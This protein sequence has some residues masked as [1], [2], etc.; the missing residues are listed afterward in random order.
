[1]L[2]IF[3]A[4]MMILPAPFL[5]AD[6]NNADAIVHNTAAW[7]GK[8]LHYELYTTDAYINVNSGD[9]GALTTDPSDIGGW[10]SPVYMWGFT[11]VDPGGPYAFD[12]VTRTGGLNVQTVPAGA[13]TSAGGLVGNAKFPAPIIEAGA[14]DDVYIT[15][16]NRGFFQ[17]RQAVQDEH[18][19]HLH[20][21]HAQ[22]VYDGFPES[23]GSYSEMM[24]MF[25]RS[26]QYGGTGLL[27]DGV[28]QLKNVTNLAPAWPSASYPLNALSTK[29]KDDWWNNLDAV[30]QQ[31][32][33]SDFG[34][35]IPTVLNALSPAGGIP[36][37]FEASMLT[38]PVDQRE[39][40]TQY[41]YYFRA[42]TPGTTMYHCHVVASEHVQMG[43]YGALVIRPRD[44][45]QKDMNH[46]L[47]ADGVGKYFDINYNGVR[48][49]NEPYY[50]D[51]DG[52]S[53]ISIGDTRI[54]ELILKPGP[55]PG[56]QTYT[57]AAG[58]IVNVSKTVYGVG[59]NS[60][61][62][63]EY[64]FL[65]SEVDPVWHQIIER[66]KGSFYPPNWKPQLWFVNGRT[67][68][69]TVFP[70]QN[71]NPEPNPNLWGAMWF[72]PEPR[73][74]T[75][76]S[77]QQGDRVLERWI[78]MGYQDHSMHQHGWHMELVGTDMEQ[79]RDGLGVPYR[80]VKFTLPIASGET[81]DT[82]TSVDPVYGEA[83]Y[84]AGSPI[85]VTNGTGGNNLKWRA[86]YP[87]HD[88]NDYMVTTNG[89]YP[90]G[91]LILFEASVANAQSPVTWDNPYTG[92]I[93]VLPDA[94]LRPS[95]PY[96]Y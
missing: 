47:S 7:S 63:L 73:Y 2:P 26:P 5:L 72:K 12:P 56:D 83:G 42:V 41:T 21:I 88:H 39:A 25:W 20:G 74:N 95:S 93:E 89:I 44:Y 70:Y 14:G 58:S 27:G 91:G 86:I 64:M 19:L 3:I 30:T 40:E 48:D 22:A 38:L 1:M 32:W 50:T 53:I 65:L 69:E 55:N 92:T 71:S 94:P 37:Q 76:M 59:T 13:L 96:G 62:E 57:Y 60:E 84:A 28:T 10:P 46:V 52:D 9:A 4:M 18:T 87:I 45:I 6:V 82:I 35:T 90:G 24:N 51:I 31:K 33:M 67:F 77:A 34:A 17:D 78:N 79:Y 85:S 15:V 29:M 43:M 11:D 61:Y 16:H 36:S 49:L 80:V 81:Y 66:G 54:D 8:T 75:W 68:P 23:A